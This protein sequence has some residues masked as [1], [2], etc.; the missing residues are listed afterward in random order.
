MLV[1]LYECRCR[2]WI[3]KITSFF[4][5]FDGC[6]VWWLFFSNF[7]MMNAYT[8]V[9]STKKCRRWFVL[10]FSLLIFRFVLDVCHPNPHSLQILTNEICAPFHNIYF[11]ITHN[12]HAI[13]Y[14]I[15]W[16]SFGCLLHFCLWLFAS[17]LII[18]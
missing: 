17:M 15:W 11:N 14:I 1:K 8:K 16:Y 6:L 18:T 10:S 3:K 2:W 4:G 12:T 9:Q 5:C 7:M 13:V